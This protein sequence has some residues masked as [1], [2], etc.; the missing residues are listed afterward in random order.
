MGVG[1]LGDVNQKLKVLLK[2]HK[3]YCSILRIK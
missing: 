2:G 3:R 1:G